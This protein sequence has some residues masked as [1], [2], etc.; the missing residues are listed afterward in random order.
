VVALRTLGCGRRREPAGRAAS[1][2]G[3]LLAQTV[4][5]AA[6]LILVTFVTVGTSQ[7]CIG[8][9][10][11]TARVTQIGQAAPQIIAKQHVVVN[12]AAVASSVVKFAIKSAACCGKGSGHC[13]G[14]ACAGSSC[15]QACSA[16]VIV[17]V[18]TVDRDLTPHL[19]ILPLQTPVP[20]TESNAQFRPPRIIL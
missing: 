10:N 13:G 8:G 4:L 5:V 9:T 6:T 1:A 14:L 16:G 15:C 18:W 17:A 20:L 11:P 19:D 7:A 3:H 12:Q 2:A